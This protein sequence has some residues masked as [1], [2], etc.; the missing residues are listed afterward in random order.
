MTRTQGAVTCTVGWPGTAAR[1]CSRSTH[2]NEFF[3]GTMSR[4]VVVKRW[5]QANSKY[6]LVSCETTS[7]KSSLR[8]TESIPGRGLV[9]KHVT[10]V[11]QPQPAS[12]GN[13]HS[14]CRGSIQIRTVLLPPV[15]ETA[16]RPHGYEESGR[17]GK[18]NASPGS[19][20]RT[21]CVSNC[22]RLAICATLSRNSCRLPVPRRNPESKPDW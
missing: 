21:S 15:Q 8:C 6:F 9:S 20:M 14:S 12:A 4:S 10:N 2:R 13:E 11:R 16:E 7:A 19:P 18:V 22:K 3:F 1:R 5:T 17:K